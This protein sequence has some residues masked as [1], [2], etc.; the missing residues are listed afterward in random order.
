MIGRPW[1]YDWG[2]VDWRKN[3]AFVAMEL[4]CSIQTV[5]YHRKMVGIMP[6]APRKRTHR[7]TRHHWGCMARW[8]GAPWYLPDKVIARRMGCSRQ[9]VSNWRRKLRI[10]RIVRTK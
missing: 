1:K 7:W 10:Q 4:G 9:N 8:R 6:D 3:D 5:N 2:G